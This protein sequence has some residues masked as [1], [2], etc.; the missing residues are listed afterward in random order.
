MICV[1]C[2][3]ILYFL[4]F[5]SKPRPTVK[6]KTD[7]GLNQK[8]YN[9]NKELLVQIADALYESDGYQMIN[10]S[11]EGHKEDPFSDDSM[12]YDV[13]TYDIPEVAGGAINIGLLELKESGNKFIS[14]VGAKA[15]LALREKLE[16]KQE[17]NPWSIEKRY[18]SLQAPLGNYPYIYEGTIVMFKFIT[19]P[20]SRR[21][22][23]YNAGMSEEDMQRYMGD[24]DY[25]E[26][27]ESDW[28]SFRDEDA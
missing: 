16:E 1:I 26:L 22:I 4:F 8:F 21:G 7:Y 17:N 23:L 24:C 12:I 15:I 27:A 25:L 11:S 6:D 5:Y 10:Y 2:S 19:G 14:D 3:L 28:Y 20:D 13:Y 18:A 9:E